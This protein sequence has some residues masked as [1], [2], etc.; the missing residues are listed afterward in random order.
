MMEAL[1]QQHN[2]EQDAMNEAVKR[3]EKKAMAGL[4]DLHGEVYKKDAII[5]KQS[6]EIAALQLKAE[7][8]DHLRYVLG[9]HSMLCHL[10]VLVV[11]SFVVGK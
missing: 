8:V 7:N 2:Q 10:F 6:E 3:I 5:K 4:E 1:E 11:I 9:M